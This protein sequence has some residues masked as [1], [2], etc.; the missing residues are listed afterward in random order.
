MVIF[1]SPDKRQGSVLDCFY[2]TKLRKRPGRVAEASRK[3]WRVHLSPLGQMG[4]QSPRI[5]DPRILVPERVLAELHLQGV[6]Q[7]WLFW[8]SKRPGRVRLSVPGGNS[9]QSIPVPGGNVESPQKGR[10]FC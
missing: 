5:W 10:V 1:S 6:P 8:F 7:G 9:D 3:G 2:K 4:V